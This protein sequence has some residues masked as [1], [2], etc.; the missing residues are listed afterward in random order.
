M[1][2]AVFARRQGQQAIIARRDSLRSKLR[3]G[4]QLAAVSLGASAAP[5]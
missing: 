4:M 5:S 2:V 3:L 1:I